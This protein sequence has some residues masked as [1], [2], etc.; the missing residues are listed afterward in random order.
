MDIEMK[1]GNWVPISKAFVK[2]LPKDRKF[3]ELEAIFSLQVDCDA[4]NTITVLGCASRFQWSR[5]KVV[6]FFS[7]VGIEIEYHENTK[8][9]R[10]QKGHISIHKRDINGTYNGQIRFV[11]SNVSQEQKDIKRTNEGHKEDITRFT[12][13]KPNPKPKD[14]PVETEHDISCRMVIDHLN[15]K[16]GKK[17]RY[18]K[19]S[20]EP[21]R[22]RFKDNYTVDDCIKVLNTKWNDKDFP[23]K[24]YQPSTLFRPGNFENYLNQAIEKE[25]EIKKVTLFGGIDD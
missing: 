3:T 17:F 4:G 22:A 1:H 11:N 15:K 8:K 16:A 13:I 14:S 7:K 23:E 20:M 24:Y 25:P 9:K 6:T 21:I 2:H 19:A 10:N 18:S 12:T 5:N